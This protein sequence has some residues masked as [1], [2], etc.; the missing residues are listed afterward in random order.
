MNVY[1]STASFKVTLPSAILNTAMADYALAVST[2][3]TAA[4]PAVVPTLLT[5]S[6]LLFS[7]VFTSEVAAGTIIDLTI[8]GWTNPSSE[9]AMA[10]TFEVL[11]DSGDGVNGLH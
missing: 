3:T 2:G 1:P 4:V 7:D 6:S 5:V 9:T 8:T 11:W 10:V